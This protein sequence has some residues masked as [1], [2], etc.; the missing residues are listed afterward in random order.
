M[1]PLPYSVKGKESDVFPKQFICIQMIWW[2]SRGYAEGICTE[3]SLLNT[4][5]HGTKERVRFKTKTIHS[6]GLN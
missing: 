1:I 2:N 6:P 4:V 3:E 5:K